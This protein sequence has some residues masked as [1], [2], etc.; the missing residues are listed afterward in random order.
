MLDSPYGRHNSVESGK[1]ANRPEEVQGG[2]GL[3]ARKCDQRWFWFPIRDVY[4]KQAPL[5]QLRTEKLV[6]RL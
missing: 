3:R 2:V 6:V 1:R 4:P 5:A